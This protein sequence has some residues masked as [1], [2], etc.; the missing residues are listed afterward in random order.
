VYFN[1]GTGA[2][3]DYYVKRTV[4]LVR[5]CPADGYEQ[6][7]VRVS[8]TNTAPQNAAALLPEY[9]TGGGVFGVPPGSVQTN[10]VAYGPVQAQVESAKVDGQKTGFSPYLHAGRPVGILSQR[11]EPGQS[12]TIEFT[13]GKIA[14][15]DE[16]KVFVSPGLQPL[17]DVVL[18]SLGASCGQR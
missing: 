6:V 4:Q 14:Q 16:P 5:D 11:L 2:K 15:H 10:V 13:F 12:R 18:P 17:Q 9:V 7:T 3:M 8:S 1:D